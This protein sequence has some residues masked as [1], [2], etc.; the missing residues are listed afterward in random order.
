MGWSS[1]TEDKHL[2]FCRGE[3]HGVFREED[4]IPSLSGFKAPG[5]FR[6]QIKKDCQTEI[7]FSEAGA[8][9]HTSRFSR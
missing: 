6:G 5:K 7:S 2:G 4:E 9:Q 1:P 8:K 3:F